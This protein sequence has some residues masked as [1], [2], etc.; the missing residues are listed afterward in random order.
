MR[1][2]RASR[3]GTVPPKLSRGRRRRSHHMLRVLPL[4][5]PVAAGLLFGGGCAGTPPPYPEQLAAAMTTLRA[6]LVEVVPEEERHPA[7]LASVDGFEEALLAAHLALEELAGRLAAR[8]ADPAG[9]TAEL[10]A[11]VEA[12]AVANRAARAAVLDDYAAFQRGLSAAE[13]E[14]LV[15][16][17][18]EAMRPPREALR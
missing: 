3:A 17:L 11:L 10:R 7:L 9:T 12:D 1:P 14:Q 5:L 13:W 8:N 15:P 2:N 16:A 18:A 4:A 6:R